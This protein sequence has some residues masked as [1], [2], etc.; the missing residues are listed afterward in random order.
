MGSGLDGPE[1]VA[2]KVADIRTLLKNQGDR[3]VTGAKLAQV[4][5]NSRSSDWSGYRE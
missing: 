1:D 2:L 3:L 5:R 4:A